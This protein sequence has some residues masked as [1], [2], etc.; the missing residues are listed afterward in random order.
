MFRGAICLR[1]LRPLAA[2]WNAIGAP[3]LARPP[4]STLVSG[5]N[6]EGGIAQ[7]IC[8]YGVGLRDPF[9]GLENGIQSNVEIGCGFGERE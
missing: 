6:A 5:F 9:W 4:F 8:I 1:D 2:D 7:K 3:Q